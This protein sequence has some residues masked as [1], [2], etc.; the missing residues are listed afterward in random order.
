MRFCR[1]EKSSVG[2]SPYTF[3]PDLSASVVACSGMPE[4][5]STAPPGWRGS[6][7][8]LAARRLVKG[9]SDAHTGSRS[10]FDRIM[11]IAARLEGRADATV[12][13]GVAHGRAVRLA[14][15]N[16]PISSRKELV[17]SKSSQP[18]S[19]RVRWAGSIVNLNRS[20]PHT[21]DCDARS[22]VTAKVGS[23]VSAAINAPVS[24]SLNTAVSNPFLVAFCEK[25]HRMTVQSH[26]GYR[27][28]KAHR[29]PPHAKNH[30][31]NC[32][33]SQQ[34]SHPASRAD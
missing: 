28:H 23:R 9:C 33:R 34:F 19:R 21:I 7:L 14:A 26:T 18:F 6:R 15:L 4:N 3:L 12:Y 11:G 8:P 13:E 16:L 5:S 1:Y 2:S 25:Y 24:A 17:T 32:A 22:T 20:S 10:K 30:R 27:S 31:Q 29:L